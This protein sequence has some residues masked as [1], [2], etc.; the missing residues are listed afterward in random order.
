MIKC[1]NLCRYFFFSRVVCIEIYC[2]FLHCFRHF[3]A[4]DFLQLVH[5]R[6]DCFR[7]FVGHQVQQTLQ[8]AGDQDIHGW[9]SRQNEVAVAIICAGIEEIDQDFVLV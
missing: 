3:I 9:G 8:V 6:L 4:A 1:S 7:T 5:E 2:F